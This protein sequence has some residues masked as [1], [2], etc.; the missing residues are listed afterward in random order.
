M[1]NSLLSDNFKNLTIFT[2]VIGGTYWTRKIAQDGK[3][4]IKFETQNTSMVERSPFQ[5]WSVTALLGAFYGYLALNVNTLLL[6]INFVDIDTLYVGYS[7]VIA[8]LTLDIT[9]EIYDYFTSK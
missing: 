6:N 4:L 7:V 3:N 9:K 2:C 8:G 1:N 5:L